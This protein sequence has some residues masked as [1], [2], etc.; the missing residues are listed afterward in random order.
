MLALEKMQKFLDENPA[1]AKKAAKVIMGMTENNC[2]RTLGLE[3]VGE[4]KTEEIF[5]H[6]GKNHKLTILAQVNMT[7]VPMSKPYV[8]L[9]KQIF[10]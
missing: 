3:A 7:P 9:L 1:L 2:R 4:D 6:N 10:G 5:Q 8:C